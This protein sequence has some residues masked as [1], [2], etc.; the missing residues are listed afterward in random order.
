LPPRAAGDDPTWPSAPRGRSPG[1]AKGCDGAGGRPAST[2]NKPTWASSRSVLGHPPRLHGLPEKRVAVRQSGVMIGH[3]SEFGLPD[4]CRRSR[5][6]FN[7][8]SAGAGRHDPTCLIA[9]ARCFETEGV[10]VRWAATRRR[11][12]AA[13]S[14]PSALYRPLWRSRPGC[15]LKP[16]RTCAICRPIRRV[17]S[18]RARASSTVTNSKMAIDRA[19]TP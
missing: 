4:R 5:R 2:S 18:P 17:R 13:V 12:P 16:R 19:T 14:S 8:C 11:D 15:I 7:L 10:D 3:M 1:R 6:L 9:N